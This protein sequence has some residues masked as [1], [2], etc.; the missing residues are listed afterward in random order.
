[1]RA[2]RMIRLSA[3]AAMALSVVFALAT[4]LPARKIDQMDEPIAAGNGTAGPAQ[5]ADSGS[6]L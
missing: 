1:M 6:A 3:I 5:C 4:D 2:Q